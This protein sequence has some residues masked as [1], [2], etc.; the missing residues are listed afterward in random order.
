MKENVSKWK[1]YHKDI[2]ILCVRWYLKYPLSYRNIQEMMEERGLFIIHTRHNQFTSKISV[3]SLSLHS[4]NDLTLGCLFNSN[5]S[6]FLR[7]AVL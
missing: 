6:F 1:H 5:F 2:I 3:P 4:T 7:V